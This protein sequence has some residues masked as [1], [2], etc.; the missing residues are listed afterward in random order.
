MYFDSISPFFSGDCSSEYSNP[1]G[2]G[3]A[4]RIARGKKGFWHSGAL[5]EAKT[6]KNGLG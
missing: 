6:G 2:K 4:L 1:V 3:G 5:R